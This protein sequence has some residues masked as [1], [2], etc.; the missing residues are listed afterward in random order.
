MQSLPSLMWTCH[1]AGSQ[2]RQWSGWTTLK[3]FKKPKCDN[4]SVTAIQ[5]FGTT[6]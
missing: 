6:N 4:T 1:K 2:S 3:P 5:S